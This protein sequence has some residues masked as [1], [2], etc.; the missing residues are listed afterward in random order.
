[1]KATDMEKL[2]A[3]FAG[4]LV[5][6]V[7]TCLMTCIVA[8]ISTVAVLGWTSDFLGP[9]MRAWL[10]SWGVAFPIMI[11]MLPVARRIVRYLV[12]DE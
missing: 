8:G 7:L 3:R 5:P 10:M 9:W 4:V 6:F 1:M 12:K 2:P 11:L